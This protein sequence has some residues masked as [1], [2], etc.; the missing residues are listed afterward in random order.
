[1]TLDPMG[2]FYWLTRSSRLNGLLPVPSQGSGLTSKKYRRLGGFLLSASPAK[3]W[4]A[5]G[6]LGRKSPCQL[7]LWLAATG[8][9]P[10]FEVL[11]KI[12]EG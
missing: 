9:G 2:V 8:V 3:G 1:M 10:V 12:P 6:Y 7:P 4:L 11:F 5:K